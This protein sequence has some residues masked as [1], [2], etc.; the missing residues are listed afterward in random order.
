MTLTFPPSGGTDS[1]VTKPNE[2]CRIQGNGVWCGKTEI[3][4][5]VCLSFIK[6][7]PTE[8]RIKSELG[9]CTISV[10]FIHTLTLCSSLI[11]FKT[12]F[13]PKKEEESNAAVPVQEATPTITS[14]D[15]DAVPVAAVLEGECDKGLHPSD[16][17]RVE[18]AS[19]SHHASPNPTSLRVTRF[20][21]EAVE[22]IQR[23]PF[24]GLD[25]RY[26]LARGSSA[27]FAGQNAP[28]SDGQA[29][30]L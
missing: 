29:L 2:T 27:S 13:R 9:S 20:F 30:Q 4:S 1:M 3:D 5:T 8:V 10:R 19:L 25:N 21:L 24:S 22:I 18:S 17:G 14:I 12:V 6:K 15:M 16:P 11:P 28:M 23:P 7:E 26:S